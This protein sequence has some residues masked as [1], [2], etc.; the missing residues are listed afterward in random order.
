MFEVMIMSGRG[1]AR[2]I[3]DDFA[4]YI[5]TIDDERLEGL[6]QFTG[7]GN[8]LIYCDEL[9]SLELSD[10]LKDGVEIETVEE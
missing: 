9:G 1:Y 5:E 4:T 2:K 6:R 3:G 10:V 7:E 8:L